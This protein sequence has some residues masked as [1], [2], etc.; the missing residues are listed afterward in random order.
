MNQLKKLAN[1]YSWTEAPDGSDGTGDGEHDR[2][3]RAPKAAFRPEGRAA[4]A[5][6]PP[7]DKSISIDRALAL[8]VWGG[9][10]VRGAF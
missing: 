9:A 4:G 3:D 7:E 1:R 8:Y 5:L 6:C 2:G 10:L